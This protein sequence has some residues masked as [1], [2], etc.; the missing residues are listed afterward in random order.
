LTSYSV[1]GTTVNIFGQFVDINSI[2]TYRIRYTYRDGA[3]FLI[4]TSSDVAFNNIKS[5]KYPTAYATPNPSQSIVAPRCQSSSFNISFPQVEFSNPIVIPEP[6]YAPVSTYEYPLPANWTLNSVVSNGTNWL[7]GSNNVTVT[8][9]LSRGDGTSIQIR[10]IN[11]F[12]ASLLRGPVGY[13]PISRPSPTLTISTDAS[14]DFC[15]GSRTY[16]MNGMP[17]GA[18]VCWSVSD[19]SL[20]SIPPASCSGSVVV[21]RAGTGSADVILTGTVTHCS[22]T[23]T[24]TQIIRVGSPGT[25]GLTVTKYMSA[26]NCIIINPITPGLNT[27]ILA[28]SGSTGY[29]TGYQ[30]ENNSGAVISTTPSQYTVNGVA[31]IPK[32]MVQRASTNTNSYVYIQSRIQNTCG[33]S[34]W[35]TFQIYTCPPGTTSFTVSPNPAKNNISISATPQYTSSG[36]SKA[37]GAGKTLLN[38][39]NSANKIYG[40]II[41]DQLGRVRKTLTY[42]TGADNVNI[43]VSG[44]SAGIY[45]LSIFDGQKWL[46]EKV[47]VQ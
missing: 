14:G 41:R 1:T 5:F 33:W 40:V 34:D 13:V 6:H 25:N 45:F 47:V 9:D 44:Y 4:T 15:S 36:M 3:G 8:S 39:N 30:T 16:T 12:G 10:A 18:S 20:A 32:F 37:G 28:N 19:P 24:Q 29:T 2:Q 22:F 27:F 11:P 46:N 35:K 23:Y 38:G 42:K 21:T 7:P 26:N 31:T 17:T 43:S